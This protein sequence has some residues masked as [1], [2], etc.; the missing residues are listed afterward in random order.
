MFDD[1]EFRPRWDGTTSAGQVELVT[2]WPDIPFEILRHDPAVY[3]ARNIWSEDVEVRWGA[4]QAAFAEL[5][6]RGVARIV[7]GAGHDIY[8][9]APDVAVAAIR[10]VQVAAEDDRSSAAVGSVQQLEEVTPGVRGQG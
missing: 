3:A 9:D 5:S 10:R 7:P 6:P 4:D 2:A 8:L 1:E